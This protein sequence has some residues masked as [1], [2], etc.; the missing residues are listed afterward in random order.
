MRMRLITLLSTSLISGCCLAGCGMKD[1]ESFEQYEA[2]MN[3]FLGVA[4]QMGAEADANLQMT[5]KGY[6]GTGG[7]LDLGANGSASLRL[8]PGAISERDLFDF[9][10]ELLQN[11][12]AIQAMFTKWADSIIGDRVGGLQPID[13]GP[14]GDGPVRGGEP[15]GAGP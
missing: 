15:G 2:K 14:T 8:R 9:S 12:L 11:N 1:G 4:K 6:I 3:T 7:S 5:G 13:A 10:R